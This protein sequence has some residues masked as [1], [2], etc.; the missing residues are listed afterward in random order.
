[1]AG[2]AFLPLTLLAFSGKISQKINQNNRS[3]HA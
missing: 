3:N 1:M 2:E